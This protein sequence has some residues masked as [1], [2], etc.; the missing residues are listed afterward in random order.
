VVGILFFGLCGVLGIRQTIQGSY[1]EL[2]PRGLA[3]SGAGGR[4]F[5]P[6]EAIDSAYRVSTRGVEELYITLRDP[7]ALQGSG[8]VTALAG[9]SRRLMGAEVA[10]PLSQ[11]TAHPDEVEGAVQAMLAGQ[12]F[13]AASRS[14]EQELMQ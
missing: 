1:V 8:I 10:V 11:L 3:W 12:P 4:F 13:G 14:S 6:W 5:A 7:S 2:T 9:F